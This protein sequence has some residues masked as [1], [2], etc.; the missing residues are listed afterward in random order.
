MYVLQ[1]KS[2]TDD[3]E[4]WQPEEE[5]EGEGQNNEEE[6]M[7]GDTA[8]IKPRELADLGLQTTGDE[9][10]TIARYVEHPYFLRSLTQPGSYPG[11]PPKTE[12]TVSRKVPPQQK[13]VVPQKRMII[14][15]VDSRLVYDIP[16]LQL[17]PPP[18]PK[19]TSAND[20]YESLDA[21]DQDIR[22]GQFT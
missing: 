10:D 9:M 20:I 21:R 2:K 3:D 17:P 15:G 11:P 19:G 1:R 7:G 18:R 4:E 14:E 22:K 16:N 6:E 8:P 13:T 12:Q 5:G